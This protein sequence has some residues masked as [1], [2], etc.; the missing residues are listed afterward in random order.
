MATRRRLLVATGFAVLAPGW[1]TAQVRPL[2]VGMLSARPL[3]ESLYA[4]EIV[5]R[6]AALGYRDG[7]RIKLEFRAAG[8]NPDAYGRLARELASLNCDLIFA[9]GSEG[10]ARALRDQRSHI[11]VVFLAADYDP[12]EKGLVQSLARPG[13]SITGVFMPAK[14][15][16]A[17]RI[18]LLREVMPKAKRFLVLIDPMSRD[19]L[20]TIRS[21]AERSRVALTVADFSRPPYEFETAFESA[22]KAGIEGLVVPASPVF[23]ANVV[24]LSALVTKHRLPAVGFV[25][26]AQAGF[27]LTYSVDNRKV[28]ART[29]ELAVK[30]L[31]GA[32]PAE[33]PVEQPAEYVLVVNLRSARDLGIKIPYSVLA[34]ATSVLE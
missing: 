20:D 13:G 1:A 6:L 12:L 33:I 10:S 34:R 15:L 27:L 21:A 25:G 28:A 30:V 4:S 5:R 18:E 16:A 31:E 29:A 9:V 14:E 8:A 23:A 22:R 11:P 17:K 2:K 7:E 26:T 19:Q 24:S 32:K 3:S